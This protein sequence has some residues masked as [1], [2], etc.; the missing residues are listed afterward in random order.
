MFYELHKEKTFVIELRNSID[1]KCKT[2]SL[3]RKKAFNRLSNI[4]LEA[5][6]NFPKTVL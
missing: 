6:S 1:L 3:L 4:L 2:K 5:E